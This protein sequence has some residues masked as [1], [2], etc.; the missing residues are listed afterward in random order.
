MARRHLAAVRPLALAVLLALV[1]GCVAQ[2]APPS[3]TPT[4]VATDAASL[5]PVEESFEGVAMGSPAAPGVS[6]FPFEVPR[7]AVGLNGTLSY[8]SPAARIAFELLDPKGEVVSNGYR[9]IED[10]LVVVTVEPPRPGTWTF[11]VRAD[12]AVNVPFRIDAVAQLIVP[13]DNTVRRTVDLNAGSF[14]E[15]NMILEADASFRF[16]F[17]A[18]GPVRWDVHSH[19]PGGVKEW[20]SGEGDSASGEFKAPARDV[21]SVLLENPGV[22]VVNAQFEAVGAFRLHSHSG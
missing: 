13:Q 12:L 21:Y 15:L 17:N 2:D 8:E 11:R 9:D 6:E 16:G 1:A 18:T 7:G 4:D 3:A 5:R 14:Y 10:N 20:Q 22:A 19:P